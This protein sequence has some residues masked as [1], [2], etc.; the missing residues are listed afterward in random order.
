MFFCFYVGILSTSP[1]WSEVADNGTIAGLST[2]AQVDSVV[3]SDNLGFPVGQ[4]ALQNLS[5]EM[6]YQT[7]HWRLLFKRISVT[8][9]RVAVISIQGL[10]VMD[11]E[12]DATT[13]QVKFFSPA[14]LTQWRFPRWKMCLET[15]TTFYGR[16]IPKLE[17][18]MLS[19]RRS[20][21]WHY[22]IL[23]YSPKDY[24]LE[25]QLT[26]PWNERLTFKTEKVKI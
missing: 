12:I 16:P 23:E 18:E 4:T 20:T 11:A 1:L 8:Q 19:G 14:L 2:P 26:S 17:G 25:I 5:L 13:G 6:P 15:V 3:S 21:R 9:W 7:E 24:P 22:K 10:K